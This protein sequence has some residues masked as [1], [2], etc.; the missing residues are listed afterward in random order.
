MAKYK[1]G[2]KIKI[3]EDLEGYKYYGGIYC[4][5]DMAERAG[6]IVT[7]TD[8][9][10]YNAFS[11]QAYQTYKISDD[12]DEYL[13]SAEMFDDSYNEDDEDNFE[14]VEKIITV[15]DFMDKFNTTTN[16]NVALYIRDKD[17]RV[18][19]GCGDIED[20][21]LYSTFVNAYG[22]FKVTSISFEYDYDNKVSIALLEVKP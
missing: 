14:F 7:I 19:M 12:E 4:N 2:D 21:I 11:S 8:I 6:E 15:Q 5:S 9:I 17:Y 16:T 3:R 1:I 22:R 10:M 13:W 20:S 18:T